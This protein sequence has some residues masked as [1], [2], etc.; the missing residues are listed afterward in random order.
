[1]AQGHISFSEVS[2]FRG[3]SF[4]SPGSV[5]SILP[6]FEQLWWLSL[7]EVCHLWVRPVPTLGGA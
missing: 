3:F 5:M 7:R 1:M 4:F 2:P 6:P